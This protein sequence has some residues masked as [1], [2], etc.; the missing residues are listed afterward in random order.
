MCWGTDRR[1]AVRT[2]HRLWANE[3]LPGELAQILP[4]PRHFE[5]ASELVTEERR[6]AYYCTKVLP[7]LRG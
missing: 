7:L 5:R 2:A 1:E 4:T 3:Q 6:A